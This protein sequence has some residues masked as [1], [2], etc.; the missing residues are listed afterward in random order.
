MGQKVTV[1]DVVIMYGVREKGKNVPRGGEC[2]TYFVDEAERWIEGTK[3]YEV[4]EVR[5]IPRSKPCLE[6]DSKNLKGQ[7]L[8]ERLR[9]FVGW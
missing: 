6:K 7:S 2:L 4:V 8:V 5:I 3:G 9:A 1:T